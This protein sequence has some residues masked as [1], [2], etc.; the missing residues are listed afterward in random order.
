MNAPNK[1]NS[2]MDWF[3]RKSMD[4]NYYKARQKLFRECGF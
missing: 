3:K 1:P 2:I 4:G